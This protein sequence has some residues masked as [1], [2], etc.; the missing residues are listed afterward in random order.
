MPSFE[1]EIVSNQRRSLVFVGLLVGTFAALAMIFAGIYGLLIVA[2]VALGS[3]FLGVRSV[4]EV[5]GARLANPEERAEGNLLRAVEEISIAAGIPTPK[6]YVLPS[7]H[8][9]AFAA[10]R[11]NKEAIVCFTTAALSTWNTE[12]LQGVV[13]HE[14]SHII[15]GDSRLTTFASAFLTAIAALFAFLVIAITVAATTPMVSRDKDGRK[16]EGAIRAFIIMAGI[17]ALLITGIALVCAKLNFFAFS[18]KREF[19]ADSTGVKLARNTEGLASALE[20]IANG[21]PLAPK[22]KGMAALFTANPF[23][24][25]GI[26]RRLVDTHPPIE[27]RVRRLRSM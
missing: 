8:L 20:K 13:A 6:V 17:A 10:S 18:R 25:V 14:I 4:L 11:S 21:P 23:G 1:D 22:Y 15:N 26:F 16:A 27:E 2:I 3:W 9:N 5:S 7:E 24:G 12:E 19:L